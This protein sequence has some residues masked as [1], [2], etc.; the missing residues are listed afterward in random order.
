[1]AYICGKIYIFINFKQME[2]ESESQSVTFS[3]L[4]PH[5][6]LLDFSAHGDSLG[7]NTGV[8]THSLLQGIFPT[9]G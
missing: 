4:K 6:Y 7:K 9:Q 1:M 5:G 2:S 3:S 8:G